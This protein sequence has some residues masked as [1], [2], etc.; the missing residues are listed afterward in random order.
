V[1]FQSF[2]SKQ[3]RVLSWWCPSSADRDLEG[4]LCDGA[5]RSGKTFCMGLSFFCW[6]MATFNGQRFGICGATKASVERNILFETV[7]ALEDLGFQISWQ[8]VKGQLTVRFGGHENVFFLYGGRNEGSAGLIQGV[9]LAGVLLDE[10]VIM[11]RSFVEQACAR[12]SVRGA[13][14]WLNCNPEG[15]EHWLYR[16]WV[17]KAEEK[18]LLHLHFTMEDNPALDAR[19]RKRYARMFSG[20]FYR[21]FVLGEWV[22]A[23]GLVYDFFREEMMG[24]VPAEGIGPWRISCDYG[25]VN[26]TSFG[27]WGKKNGVWYRVK[28]YYY[29]ARA[30]GRQKTDREYVEDLLSLAGGRKIER[31]IVDPSAASFIEAL[32]RIGMNVQKA[33]NRVVDG[34]RV[35]AEKLK[36]GEIVIC[37]G[38]DAALREFQ[39]YCW[40]KKS[41]EDKVIKTHDH[42][43]DEIRYFAMSVEKPEVPIAAVC[44]ERIS[45]GGCYEII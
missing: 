23:E 22:A 35:T 26:P 36:N 5:V 32:R 44:V 40:D 2:S 29:D 7:S 18:R 24:E 31:V 1:S 16:E 43:M 14:V 11:P 38:C 39:L 21:R 15:P 25:T 19:T 45:Q 28:E 4:I 9:T 13:K 34:I 3:K 10:A 12:C 37:K 8:K 42:A 33:D 30:E 20:T 41:G 17:C 27:L 6:A